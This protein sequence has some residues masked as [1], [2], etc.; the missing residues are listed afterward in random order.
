MVIIEIYT[1]D[2][3]NVFYVKKYCNKIFSV[4]FNS[5]HGKSPSS[6]TMLLS[7][8]WPS[9]GES[10]ASKT[11][12]LWMMQSRVVSETF[13]EALY[14]AFFQDQ[15]VLFFLCGERLWE[16]VDEWKDTTQV[17]SCW[18]QCISTYYT[19]IRSLHSWSHNASVRQQIP[20]SK[21]AAM[22]LE[23]DK[24]LSARTIEVNLGNKGLFTYPFLMPRKNGSCCFIMNLKPLNQFIPVQNSRWP[25]KI[26]LGRPSACFTGHSHWTS[27]QHT[28]TSQ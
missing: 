4:Q 25:P 14:K 26:K 8:G 12:K 27:S 22:S 13:F 5:N 3:V 18:A 9:R 6:M 7:S 19:S 15:S 1:I 2:G 17:P 21:E 16:F 20:K 23:I 28:A 24:M 10:Q 11:I